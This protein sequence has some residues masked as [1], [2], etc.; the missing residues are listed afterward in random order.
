MRFLLGPNESPFEHLSN[1]ESRLEVRGGWI[2]V[3]WARLVGVNLLAHAMPRALPHTKCV[4]GMAGRGTTAEALDLL[5]TSCGELYLY[6]KH[7]RQ[8]F[9]P[10]IYLFHDGV[11]PPNYAELLIGSSNLTGGGLFQNIEGNLALSLRPAAE[12]EHRILLDQLHSGIVG[13]I[14]SGFAER[15]ES[16]ERIKELLADGYISTEADLRKLAA[17]D[18]RGAARRGARRSRPESPPPPLPG[19]RFLPVGAF[20]ADSPTGD[21][22]RGHPEPS[23]ANSDTDVSEEFFVRTLT[24]NDINKLKGNTPGT[25][26]WDLG[27]TARNERP[28]FW[29]WPEEYS[30]ITR[31]KPRLEWATTGLIQSGASKVSTVD[32]VLWYREERDGHAAEH[33]LRIGP[34][35]LLR[36]HFP[37]DFDSDS[38]VVIERLPTSSKHRFLIQFLTNSDAEFPDYARYLA[39]DRPRHRHGYG[40]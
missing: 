28:G 20:V 10:K 18:S 22:C 9:H 16:K 34:L 7:H 32:V 15:I 5:R 13:L 25:C 1:V 4:V 6:H 3:A 33:R 40:P 31:V 37:H 19:I 35:S 39:S 26:E 11:Q 2:V 29:G 36:E 24:E 27:E 12:A 14:E 38:I 23:G 17:G 21:D 8:T 30:E